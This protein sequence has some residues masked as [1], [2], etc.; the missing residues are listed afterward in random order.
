MR[1]GR[2]SGGSNAWE[3]GISFVLNKPS[4]SSSSIAV[5][6]SNGIELGAPLIHP[7]IGINRP[8]KPINSAG[9]YQY[10]HDED[11][12]GADSKYSRDML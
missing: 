12:K 9:S 1:R 5:K 2:Q 3:G 7:S 4:G 11:V 8:P 10:L 6:E